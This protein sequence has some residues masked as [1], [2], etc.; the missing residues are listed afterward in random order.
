MNVFDKETCVR[1]QYEKYGKPALSGM[2]QTKWAGSKISFY[3]QIDSTN[4]QAKVEAREGAQNGTLIIADMQT[5]GKGRRGRTW[6]SPAGANIYFTLLIRPNFAP[7]KAS[8]L[9]LVM[10]L[11]VAKGL[12]QAFAK[13]PNAPSP[14]I[15]WPNDIVLNGKKVCGILTE[16][17]MK[18][19]QIDYVIIGVG[20][21]V[22]KQK[23]PIEIVDKATSLE[24]ECG[25]CF[26]RTNLIASIIEAFEA[27]YEVFEQRGN[28]ADLCEQYHQI[29]VNKDREVCVLD[30]KGE[31]RGIATGITD[32]G[33]LCV[34]L[35]DGSQTKV[36]AGEVS[37][38]GIYGYV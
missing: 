3:E 20:I 11:A 4:A 13:L 32:M 26:L 9:T 36:Y 23:F 27:Y 2:L 15:K 34:E 12:E 18:Q 28:L 38:R 21:N 30:P 37:V 25:Q 5:D 1:K 35:P 29:L 14:M 16:M 24:A 22:N 7:D 31:Y 17:S 19:T 8:M 10:A 6:E 33:E